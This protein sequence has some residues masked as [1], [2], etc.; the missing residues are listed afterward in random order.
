VKQFSSNRITLAGVVFLLTVLALPGVRREVCPARI[1]RFM[2]Y[3]QAAKN[4]NAPLSFRER[5]MYILS[6]A[7]AA[8]NP[9]TETS[10]LRPDAF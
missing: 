10:T 6:E 2:E 7:D 5:I 8:E 4:T 3:Y 1:R 9:R